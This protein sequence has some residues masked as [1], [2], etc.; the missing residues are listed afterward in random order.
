MALLRPTFIFSRPW[1]IAAAAEAGVM[2]A[3]PEEWY[4]MF[5]H[6]AAVFVFIPVLAGAGGYE[7]HF[8]VANKAAEKE[9]APWIEAYRQAVKMF[10]R[11]ERA[12]EAI[13][14]FNYLALDG[15]IAA[16][17]RLCTIYAYGVK[18]E[19]KPVGGLFWCGKAY[20]AGYKPA[21]RTR[22]QL[23]MEYWPE[24]KE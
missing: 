8:S 17:I 5:R 13:A 6:F 16:A 23:F 9:G 10:R 7:D 11:G 20:D 14:E 4:K 21:G 15:S 1:K 3:V 24:Y 12:P 18:N 22:H 2:S 19:V